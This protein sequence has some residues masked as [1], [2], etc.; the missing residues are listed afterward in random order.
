M[1]DGKCRMADDHGEVEVGGCDEE[2]SSELTPQG[3]LGQ[4]VGQDSNLDVSDKSPEWQ[5]WSN[6]KDA[7]CQ[8]QPALAKALERVR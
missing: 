1:A 7:V 2:Q 4:I 3:S 8:P 5:S 6:R